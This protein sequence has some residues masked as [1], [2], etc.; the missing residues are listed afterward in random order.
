MT[1]SGDG[2]VRADLET[3]IAQ[4]VLACSGLP[5]GKVYWA[6]QT[7]AARPA[8]PAIAMRMIS[9]NDSSM[10]WVDTNENIFVF[11]D[12]LI[13]SRSGNTVTVPANT[14]NTGTGPVQIVS[15]GT[16]PGG[17]AVA[18]N[19]WV[20][21]L[22]PTTLQFATSFANAMAG[23]P[24]TLT[25]NGTGNNTVV[26]QPKTLRQGEEILH[27]SRSEDR[28]ILNL[29]CFAINGVSQDA[30]MTYLRRL[31]ARAKLPTPLAILQAGHVGLTQFDRVRFVKGIRDAVLFEPR[32]YLEVRLTS[33]SEAT[34]ASNIIE[35]AQMTNQLTGIV[36]NVDGGQ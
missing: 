35:T 29:E 28:I 16:P 31:I 5:V 6:E 4:W 14:L 11:A 26:A 13:A 8:E 27:T 25:T 21:V 33:P 12:L 30:A 18:T 23:T 36:T 34:E 1:I 19:Y 22:S 20:I 10:P 24:V 3:T 2:Y 32:A 15:S 7:D 9:E 17:L